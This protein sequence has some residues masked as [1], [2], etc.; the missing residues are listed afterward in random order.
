MRRFLGKHV[1]LGCFA[2]LSPERPMDHRPLGRLPR[3][4]RPGG[5]F[6]SL[7]LLKEP[8]RLPDK[9]IVILE[10]CAV[11]GVG[12][13]AK[14]GVRQF[15]GQLRRI[16]CRHHDVVVAVNDQNGLINRGKRAFG[17]HSPFRDRRDLGVN[18]FVGH[19]GVAV[20]LTFVQPI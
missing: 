13:N 16:D 4:A 5:R 10:N 14:L 7:L 8:E 19:R 6:E 17:R 1:S 20:F 15:A 12:E 9:L 18:G 2:F 11:P 3:T